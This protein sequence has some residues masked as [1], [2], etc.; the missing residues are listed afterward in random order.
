[1]QLAENSK[2][3]CEQVHLCGNS[4]THSCGPQAVGLYQS[5]QT[6]ITLKIRTHCSSWWQILARAVQT[7]VRECHNPVRGR[8]GW[9]EYCSCIDD[10]AAFAFQRSTFVFQW[11]WIHLTGQR[12]N[13]GIYY[14]QIGV[15]Y[16][17]KSIVDILMDRNYGS[18]NCLG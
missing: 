14:F 5:N 17:S 1:V 6:S 10:G 12:H 4:F 7:M 18:L 15:I 8:A 9:H 16:A 13:T 3:R 11:L 2:M